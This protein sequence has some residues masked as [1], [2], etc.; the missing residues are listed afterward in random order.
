MPTANRVKRPKLDRTAPVRSMFG[1]RTDD[2]RSPANTVGAKNDPPP[3]EGNVA[4]GVQLGYAVIEDYLRKGQEFARANGPSGAAGMPPDPQQLAGRM[5]QYA[6]DLATTWLEYMQATVSSGPKPPPSGTAGPFDIGQ[7]RPGPGSEGAPTAAPV[8]R[9]RPAVT[10]DVHSR[11]RVE[12]SVDLKPLSGGTPLVVHDLRT[13]D[14]GQPRLTGIAIEARPEE[15]RVVVRVRIPDHQAPGTYSGLIV[16]S[17]ANLPRGS[18][19]VRIE[20]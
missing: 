20:S 3:S 2:T 10:L 13:P 8:Q 1:A 17:Q 6:S 9:S 11:Q 16:D 5:F 7:S 19:T 15:D 14:E 18:M 4:R 12:V